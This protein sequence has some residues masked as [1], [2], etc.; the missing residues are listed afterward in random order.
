MRKFSLVI[1]GGVA[2][3]TL[4]SS[5]ALADD[6]AGDP[7]AGKLVYNKCRVCHSVVKGQMKVGPSLFGVVGRTPGSLAGYK[8]SPA[9]VAFGKSGK[10]WDEATLDTYLAGPQAMIPKIKMF[11]PGLKNEKD[12]R[13]VIAYLKSLGS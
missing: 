2:A 12:R 3:L 1:A 13:D 7:A 9:M 11:F 6:A 4:G 10:V 5:A 8:Y